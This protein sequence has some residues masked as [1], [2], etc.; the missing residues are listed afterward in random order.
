MSLSLIPNQPFIFEESLPDQPCLNNDTSDYGQMVAPSDILC[1]QQIM[2]PC[3]DGIIC[4][5]DMIDVEAGNITGWDTSDGWSSS[6]ANH[7]A[8]DGSLSGTD[9]CEMLD[10]VGNAA[11]NVFY[12]TF[13][14]TSI[15]GTA[16]VYV[17]LG[18]A[19]ITDEYDSIGTYTA[20]LV[21][22]DTSDVFQFIFSNPSPI[23]GDT[24]E[25]T[26]TEFGRQA[27]IC[28]RDNINIVPAPS[29][30][31]DLNT[32]DP[33]NE[34]GYFCAIDG[35]GGD[36]I[37]DDA[38][39]IDGN[40]HSVEITVTDMTQ[41]GLEVI[42][43][44]TYLGSISVNGQYVF[45]GV[46]TDGSQQ[47]ILRPYD[48]FIGCVSQINVNNYGLLDNGDLTNS[49]HKL[50]ITNESGIAATDEI[51]FE[52]AEDR[53]TWCFNIDDITNG[54]NPVE[55]PCDAGNRLLI[56]SACEEQE[57]IEYLSIN[58]L[59][60][61]TNGWDCTFILQAYCD[62]YAFGFY[63]GSVTAP[64]FTL[65]QRLRILQ[66][67]PRYPAAAEEYLYSNGNYSRSWA[68]SGKIRQCWFDYVDEKTH[69]VI[70]LQ[71]LSDVLTID[72]EIYFA[73][74]K[75]YEPEWDDHKRNLSQSRIDL[76][77]DEVLFNSSCNV[78][79]QEPC[80]TNIV[81][82]PP[83]TMVGYKIV[84]SFDLTTVTASNFTIMEVFQGSYATQSG[85]D[86]TTVLG[87]NSIS[88]YI[89]SFF[90]GLLSGTVTSASVTY[91]APNLNI[92]VYGTGDYTSTYSGF[93]LMV[94]P[95]VVP[96]N[97]LMILPY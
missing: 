90:T 8:F 10:A 30:V 39:F 26:I 14:I 7:V 11:G 6:D 24:I 31:Y 94:N 84:G 48:N 44:S 54:G 22:T 5:D 52:I 83:S 28:W 72:S 9:I 27:G 2:N 89:Q 81:T 85:Q 78:M 79:T 73:P 18:S 49:V 15:T 38:Y 82:T 20:Y 43:G 65:I 56:T 29:W 63:F 42:L 60:Y 45:Y 69:D 93:A 58:T 37:N 74:V 12:I 35:I 66:F 57:S 88:S 91:S 40:Y 92:A 4:D 71:I 61:D 62:G 25:I 80:T 55:L 75:D 34:Y 16:G 64:V 77:K 97:V 68:Q 53:I 50:V 51:P 96:I 36:L 13:E 3:E 41:G 47:L 19:S 95:S 1:V 23:A 59:R 21:S 46:P 17:Q 70:R 33:A 32:D 86:A 67:A 87:L 76:V